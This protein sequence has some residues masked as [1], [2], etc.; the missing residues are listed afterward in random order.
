MSQQIRGQGSHFVFPI[1][2]KHKN[3]V[4]D[5]EILLPFRDFR[6]E[7][8]NVSANQ[9]CNPV[10]PPLAVSCFVHVIYINIASYLYEKQIKSKLG[11]KLYL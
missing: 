3:F 11:N 10:I 2:P 4:E 7:V 1:C 6:Q 5:V 8:G 9:L